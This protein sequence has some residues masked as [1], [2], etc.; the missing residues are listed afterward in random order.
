MHYADRRLF[1]NKVLIVAW[2]FLLLHQLPYTMNVIDSYFALKIFFR[3]NGILWLGVK[4]CSIIYKTCNL[5]FETG[6]LSA[7]IRCI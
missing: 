7:H 1:D 5:M 4:F 2:T 6:D 3:Q